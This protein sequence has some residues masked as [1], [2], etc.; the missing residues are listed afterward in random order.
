MEA[1]VASYNNRGEL[2]V[3]T[4]LVGWKIGNLVVVSD[5]GDGD[6]T[7]IT[8]ALAAATSGDTILIDTGTYDEAITIPDGIG[9]VGIDRENCIISQ[10][11]SGSQYTI[12]FSAGG[13]NYLSNCTVLNSR[14]DVTDNGAVY[15]PAGAVDLVIESVTMD[16]AN[17]GAGDMYGLWSEHT[18]GSFY[19]IDCITDG[20]AYAWYHNGAGA[21]MLQGQLGQG[22]ETGGSASGTV[23]VAGTLGGGTFSSTLI[24][25]WLVDSSGHMQAINGSEVILDADSDTSISAPTDDQIDF[26]V[27]GA[28]EAV[29]V[30]GGFGSDTYAFRI[31]NSSGGTVVAG[32]VGYIDESG[33][34]L[35]TTTANANLTWCV[36]L[37]GGTNGSDIYVARKGRVLV[38]LNANCSVGDYLYTSTTAGQASVL[39]Y[40]RPEVFAVALT[41]NGAGAGGTCEAL[42][43]TGR[44]FQAIVGLQDIIN[45]STVA[46]SQWSST[47]NGTPSGTSVVYNIGGTWQGEDAIECGGS[48][49]NLGKAVLHNTTRGDSAL[50]STVNTGTNTI[51][52][53]ATVPGTWQSG[54]TITPHSQTNTTSVSSAYWY[55][56]YCTDTDSILPLTTTLWMY[57]QVWKSGGTGY[58]TLVHPW[59]SNVGAKRWQTNN[60]L[61]AGTGASNPTNAQSLIDRRFCMLW[62]ASAPAASSVTW[63]LRGV[64]VA[65]P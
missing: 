32:D 45:Y 49:N 62:T 39:S 50:I 65:A 63:R 27:G 52:L 4:D 2:K 9:L 14:V 42:L 56:I 6:Y 37:V 58:G 47:I 7:T 51:T 60:A 59:E 40:I 21:S 20:T 43:L 33:E 35:E 16:G 31:T 44:E 53:T 8:E 1:K 57:L 61:T 25:G 10:G 48:G 64:T 22:I 55:D 13:T 15:V 30:P 54:D 38:T 26:E 18:S 28:D 34:Y 41:A 19:V 17:A 29:L 3:D 12:Q 46:R 36:V 11:T 5:S 24:S 23:C